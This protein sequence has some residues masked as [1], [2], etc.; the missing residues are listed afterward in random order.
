LKA[1]GG[2]TA[3][4]TIWGVAAVVV[5]C[6]VA[7]GVANGEAPKPDE[8]VN[9]EDPKPDEVVNGEDPKPNGF[10]VLE[11]C[12]EGWAPNP[13]VKQENLPSIHEQVQQKR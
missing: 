5:G 2:T 11:G 13:T 8:V 4:A 10:G 7:A 9:G 6:G 1:A 3:G 12:A